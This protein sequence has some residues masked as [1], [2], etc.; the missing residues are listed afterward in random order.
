VRPPLVCLTLLFLASACGERAHFEVHKRPIA[1]LP[2][3]WRRPSLNVADD[4]AHVTFSVRD[5]KGY[6]VVTPQGPSASYTD[7]GPPLFAP[8]SDRV[9]YWALDQQDER[10]TYAI[11]ANGVTSPTPF[12]NTPQIVSTPGGTR[13]A[14]LGGIDMT[15]HDGGETR[16]VSMLV[17]GTDMGRYW[18]ASVPAFSPDAR[19]VAWLVLEEG[20]RTN[21]VVDGA[22]VRTFDAATT[23]VDRE[24]F[25]LLARL[26]YLSDGRLLVLAPT[27]GGWTLF[28]DDERLATYAQSLI[29]G[30]TIVIGTKD[31]PPSIVAGSVESAK[32][33]P[34]AVWWERMSGEDERWRVVRDGAAVDGIVCATYWSTQPPVVS[35]D[36]RHIAYVCGGPSEPEV[37]LGRRTVVL[38]GRRFGPYTESWALGL[39]DDGSRVAYGA[40]VSMPVREWRMHAN[41]IPIAGPF[42]LVWRP[43][44][45]PDARHVF[46]AGGPERGRRAIG[47]DARVVTRFDDILYGP[48]FPS[49]NNPVWVIRRGRKISRIEGKLG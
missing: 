28:R 4:G 8:K 32:A 34:V 25:D 12:D 48:E 21:V 20:G 7:V 42:E 33:A 37:P 19:H 29:P 6:H 27:G 40:T 26:T 44:L 9:F 47:V 49:P 14:A 36:G 22:V 30:T 38:D 23:P 43:R 39:A 1:T 24:R 31:T 15:K 16:R 3:A 18:A 2:S 45:S 13:W 41:G 35:D 46:W 11:V 10:K 17:D 5:A